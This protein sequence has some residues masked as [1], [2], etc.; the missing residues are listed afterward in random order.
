MIAHGYAKSVMAGKIAACKWVKAACARHLGDVKASKAETYPWTFDPAMAARPISVIEKLKHTKGVWAARGESLVLEPWQLYLLA[1]TFGWVSKKTRL[2]RFRKVFWLVPRKNGKSQMCG[3][4]GLFMLACDREAGAEIYSGATTQKQ[5]F[6]VF[7]PAKVM[8]SKSKDFREFFGVEVNA[9]NLFVSQSE[10]KFEALIGKPGDG[11]S[12][13][14]SIHDEYHEHATDAQVDAMGTGMLAREQ[15]LQVIISTAG[16]NLAGPCYAAQIEAQKLLDGVIK[17]DHLFACLWT[18]DPGDRW[19][20]IKALRKANPNYGVSVNAEYLVSKL[21]EARR[22]HRKQAVYK[23][24]HLNMWVSAME[25]FFDVDAWRRCEA[26]QLSLDMFKDE[27]CRLGLDLASKVDLAALEILFKLEECRSVTAQRLREKGVEWVRFGRYWLPEAMVAQPENEHYRAWVNEG[28]LY[29]TPGNIIDF[30]EI[31][32]EILDILSNH[33]VQEVAYDPYQATMLIT[34]LEAEGVNAQ[35][36][37]ATVLSFSEPMKDLDSSILSGKIAHDGDPVMTWA[38]S[39][40]VA[41]ED[42]KE[43]VYPRKETRDKKI[44]PVVAHLSA[45][46]RWH[47]LEEGGPSMYESQGVQHVKI[48]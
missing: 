38:I 32:A 10:S 42:A 48:G 44:D 36:V 6:E 33:D 39:N 30:G 19:D 31:K 43:N 12:P 27:P 9:S 24:K 4:L 20:T 14:C 2:R 34:E 1:V 40:V 7:Q 45:L 17:N 3:A 15:P 11:A 46:A 29:E 5:A 25:A 28:W 8:A 23:T 26:P 21:H 22:N 16:S 37:R 13:S 18:V 35:E 47:K 41:R